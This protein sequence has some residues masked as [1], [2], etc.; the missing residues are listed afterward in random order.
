MGRSGVAAVVG[1]SLILGGCQDRHFLSWI[2]RPEVATA[3][4][5]SGTSAWLLTPDSSEAP[6]EFSTN[7]QA[8]TV[9]EYRVGAVELQLK[10]DA[11]GQLLRADSTDEDE[12]WP[13]PPTAEGAT[14]DPE[15]AHFIAET[16]ATTLAQR[17]QHIRV[18]PSPCGRLIL[19][20]APTIEADLRG[21]QIDTL[22]SE[23]DVALLT[24]LR[25]PEVPGIPPQA[26]LAVGSTAVPLALP[27]PV[28]AESRLLALEDV[29]GFLLVD[30]STAQLTSYRVGVDG[31]LTPR[32][33]VA[34]STRSLER[35]D[36]W[37]GSSSII[38]VHHRTGALLRLDLVT[39][40]WE[41]LHQFAEL[42]ASGCN[43]FGSNQLFYLEGPQ[44][45]LVG[46]VGIP[47]QRFS[48]RAST[49]SPAAPGL[50]LGSP[51]QSA[52]LRFPTGAELILHTLGDRLDTALD[53]RGAW[54]SGPQATWT[55]EAFPSSLYQL[56][57]RSGKAIGIEVARD[58]V[59]L[60][61][62]DPRRPDVRPR[63]CARLGVS[64][65]RLLSFD[66]RRGFAI[67]QHDGRAPI[68]LL[69]FG[70]EPD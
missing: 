61:Q 29:D 41:T 51:C 44:G 10:S 60:M 48:T 14:Y 43:A 12:A 23:G 38:G 6:L 45:G 18:P 54:R 26:L 15:G 28:T 27:N 32:Y 11:F 3:V 7:D 65:V 24:S 64:E 50:A 4:V 16:D 52:Y 22:A 31:Q 2:F 30:T 70:W 13:L 21:V 62:H 17:T 58:D 5:V 53:I 34:S 25:L 49:V 36:A 69:H 8:L 33:R 66:G 37:P 40:A 67:A 47:P 56:Q 59:A 9:L 1:L 35:F 63:I 68:R 42:G 20:D 55:T 19:L 39:G 57:A 46:F